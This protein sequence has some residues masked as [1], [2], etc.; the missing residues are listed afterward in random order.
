LISIRKLVL[1]KANEKYLFLWANEKREKEEEKHYLHY[2]YWID[3]ENEQKNQH[4]SAKYLKCHRNSFHNNEKPNFK[5]IS[6]H[7]NVRIRNLQ[8]FAILE[9]CNQQIQGLGHA[10]MCR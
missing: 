2:C 7:E 1:F 6:T 5:L 8:I 4:I 9:S 3:D 10:I